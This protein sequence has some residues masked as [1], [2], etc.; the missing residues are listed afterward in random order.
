MVTTAAACQIG[1]SK[2]SDRV[3]QQFLEMT[4]REDLAVLTYNLVGITRPYFEIGHLVLN[5][6]AGVLSVSPD[7]RKVA[8]I[9]RTVIGHSLNVQDSGLLVRSDSG[10]SFIVQNDAVP[11]GALAISS[12]LK[13][14]VL[15]TLREGGSTQV[16]V[17]DVE[18]SKVEHDFTKLIR[19]SYQEI[20]RLNV[21]SDGSRLALGARDAFFVV[22]VRSERILF[23]ASG[24][25]PSLS[26]DG[27]KLAFVDQNHRLLVGRLGE[28]M[29]PVGPQVSVEGVGSWSPNGR[30][31]LVGAW[32]SLSLSKR[33]NV[34]DTSD[35][36]SFELARLGEGDFGGHCYWISTRL[37]ALD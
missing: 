34:I 32:T 3:L 22:D 19:P 17:L 7:G 35:G 24:R 26:P 6:Y 36:R 4:A 33:L 25:F 21:S 16:L 20:E 29:E 18:T 31:L 28:R 2:D 23:G 10:E 9:P 1:C 12:D 13:R 11:K 8:W 37:L 30:F 15:T 14:A 5:D 27:R